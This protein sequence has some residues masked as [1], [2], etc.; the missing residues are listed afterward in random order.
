M[1]PAGLLAQ[2]PVFTQIKPPSRGACG[3]SVA[4]GLTAL[5]KSGSFTVAGTAPGFNRIPF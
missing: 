2:E 3:T 5:F 4:V 1:F